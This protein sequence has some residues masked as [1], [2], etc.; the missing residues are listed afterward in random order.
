MYLYNLTLQR[1]TGITCAIHGNFSG[2]KQQEIVV[3]RGKILE[4]LRHDP[5]TG[6]IYTLLTEDVFSVIRSMMPVRL[7]GGTKGILHG[8][9]L[10]KNL[11]IFLNKFFPQDYIII[12]S[13]SGRVVI[14]EYNPTKNIFEKVHQETFG[15]SG[16][17][18]IVPG[19]FLATDPKGR[20][21]M[22]GAVE[23]Q[24]LVYIL[25][26]DAQAHL[27]I[28]SP[29]EAHKSSTVCFN[30]TGVD[31]GFEN[32]M[33]A[34]LEVDYEVWSTE[35]STSRIRRSFM[36]IF[37]R[38]PTIAQILTHPRSNRT[39]RST[40]WT[41]VSTTSSESIPSLWIYLRIFSSPY[42][43]AMKDQVA[44]WYAVKIISFTRTLATK[45]TSSVPYRDDEYAFSVV[46][47]DFFNS[48]VSISSLVRPTW[49]MRI[50]AWYL[51]AAPHTKPNP[52]SFSWFRPTRATFSKLLFKPTR[53]L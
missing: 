25:N 26:R 52:C 24:K 44:C 16:C 10:L 40:N 1:P 39:S 51:F 34:C 28:S 7:T 6:K 30:L 5:N 45:W 18:R 43:V 15:K 46:F 38:K 29:L 13:D 20:A 8:R 47:V 42:Q 9:L 53:T 31:V 23:K 32:P 49:T 17:R 21:F 4:I 12:G 50:V 19:Q 33:F 22:I 27:T 35:T 14:L 3:S 36:W 2:T 11:N 41:W 48:K 37:L